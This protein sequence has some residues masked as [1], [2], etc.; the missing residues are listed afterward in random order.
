MKI[1]GKINKLKEIKFQI[2][3]QTKRYGCKDKHI[4]HSKNKKDYTANELIED[5][6]RIIRDM[7]GYP[8]NLS[9]F[10]LPTRRSLLVLSH[11]LANV[12]KDNTNKVIFKDQ[13]INKAKEKRYE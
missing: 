6:K 10:N 1:K 13:L 11:L 7:R 2:N 8:I 12:V 4:Y 9:N 5:L 3:I